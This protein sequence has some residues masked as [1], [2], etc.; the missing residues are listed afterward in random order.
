MLPVATMMMIPWFPVSG[1]ET[2]GAAS[3]FVAAFDADGDGRVAAGEL[4]AEMSSR[5]G[6]ID[7]DGD[8]FVSGAEFA[9]LPERVKQRLPGMSRGGGASSPGAGPGGRTKPNG[10][11]YAPAAREEFDPETLEVG[12]PA[13]DFRLAR[14][15]GGGEVGLADFRGGKPVVLVFGSITCAPFRDRVL[16]VFDLHREWREKAEFLM[17][18]IREAHPE[19]TLFLPSAEGEEKKL[20]KFT[21]TESLDHRIDNAR[22][23]TALLDVPFPVLVDGEDNAVKTA[24]AGWPNRLVVVAPDGKVAWD[25][26]KGPGG[27]QPARLGSWL[28]ENL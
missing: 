27:F 28:K 16:E 10:E 15:D 12:Q 6:R 20:T 4:P 17:I 2:T 24:Y 3:A 1:E 7:T 5:L 13:P 8:G 19:S 18:Y 14:S 23:C 9:A 22:Q 21:Q 26:G 25:S 11:F